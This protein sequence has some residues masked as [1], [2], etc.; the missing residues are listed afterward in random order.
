M[1]RKTVLKEPIAIVDNACRFSGDA[2]SPSKLWKLLQK[3]RNVRR[4]ISDSRFSVKGFYHPNNAHHGHF[5]VKHSYMLN[6]DSAVF[7]AEFFDINLIK[8]RAMNPQQRL[9]LKTV[10]EAIE[11]GGMTIEGLQGSDT[12]VYAGV[13]TGDYEAMLLRD[14]DAAPT[15]VAVGTSR[16]VL[17]NR[18]PYFF[19]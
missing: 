3:P 18:I 4:K 17:S 14:L 12:A 15:Y 13:M 7:D 5:N 6:D 16:A 2:N 1:T 9:L 8:A 11:S 10:Y 19:D